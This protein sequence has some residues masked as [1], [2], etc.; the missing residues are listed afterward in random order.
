MNLPSLASGWS[1][2]AALATRR[3]SRRVEPDPADLGTAFGLDM[4]LAPPRD[5][6]FECLD[7][8]DTAPA[9][10]HWMSLIAVR[11]R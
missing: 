10:L 9:P 5:S 8:R 4:S 1:W 11:R 3:A 2:L 7:P 6:D